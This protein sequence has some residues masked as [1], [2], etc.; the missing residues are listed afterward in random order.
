MTKY[1]SLVKHKLN[2]FSAWKIEH[3]TRDYNERA[4]A[5]AAVAASLPKRETVFLPIYY[6]PESSILHAQINQIEEVPRSW[7]DP[8]RLYLATG[9]LPNDRDKAH[10]VRIQSARFSMI[11]GQLYKQ[12]LGEPYLM[13]LTPEQGLYVLAE[14]HEGICGNHPGEEL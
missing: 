2:T 3:V 14:L 12:S 7:M 9:E 5:L 4:D 1:S 10:K 13:C 6:Q 11:D 8:I